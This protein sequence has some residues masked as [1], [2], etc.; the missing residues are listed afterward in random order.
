MLVFVCCGL[1]CWVGVFKCVCSVGCVSLNC[2]RVCDVLC[3][4]GYMLVCMYMCV[5]IQV[6]ILVYVCVC[7]WGYIYNVYVCD[8]LRVTAFRTHSDDPNSITGDSNLYPFWTRC[9]G[10][11]KIDPWMI[12][13]SVLVRALKT[14]RWFWSETIS[15]HV[16][17]CS[18]VFLYLPLSVCVYMLLLL[19][20]VIFYYILPVWLFVILHET[21][22]IVH[23]NFAVDMSLYQRHFM[24]W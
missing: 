9:I 16:S 17:V 10:D 1:Y 5:C 3:M 12:R 15:F 7:M 4:R 8:W 18:C 11:S 24:C 2:V 19:F 21:S 23:F 13:R 6:C 22:M 20:H 14:R